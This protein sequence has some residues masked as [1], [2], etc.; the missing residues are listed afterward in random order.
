MAAVS[1]GLPALAASA[2]RR[3]SNDTGG[4]GGLTCATTGRVCTASGGLAVGAA[5]APITLAWTGATGA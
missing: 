3:D 5:A 2:L 4:A 1:S